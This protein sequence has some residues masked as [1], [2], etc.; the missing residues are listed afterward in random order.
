M[1][2]ASNAFKLAIAAL[3]ILSG[4]FDTI[5]SPLY[6]QSTKPKTSKSSLRAESK[7]ISSTR[8]CR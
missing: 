3:M 5:G 7:S 6:T 4:A 1:G 2:E 8:L